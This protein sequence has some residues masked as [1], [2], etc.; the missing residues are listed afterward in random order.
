MLSV[1]PAVLC[2]S[3][4]VGNVLMRATEKSESIIS[5]SAS[6]L[7]KEESNQISF[8]SVSAD[9]N[10]VSD[11]KVLSEDDFSV[12]QDLYN[13]F[14]E[15]TETASEQ[16]ATKDEPTYFLTVLINDDRIDMELKGTSLFIKNE[17]R[18]IEITP[19]QKNELTEIIKHY[20][21]SE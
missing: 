1:I 8:I 20:L 10:S 18:H 11:Y 16:E 3:L 5:D 21:E 13:S 15:K 9:R 12:L 7:Q 2:L 6:D 4:A 17:N 14:Y 19:E